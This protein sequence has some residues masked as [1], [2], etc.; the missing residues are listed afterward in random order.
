MISSEMLP[1]LPKWME[2][3]RPPQR[4]YYG[5]QLTSRR[6]S[7]RQNKTQKHHQSVSI[8]KK[9]FGWST[10]LIHSPRKQQVKVESLFKIQ[11]KGSEVLKVRKK[12][13]L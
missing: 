2:G 12:R 3:F 6:Y 8:E 7:D 13:Y 5:A 1:K 10:D 11:E 4:I 9:K